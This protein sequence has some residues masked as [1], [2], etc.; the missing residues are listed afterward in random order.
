MTGGRFPNRFSEFEGSSRFRVKYTLP[1][2]WF[3]IERLNSL[4]SFS[5]DSAS[6]SDSLVPS[7]CPKRFMEAVGTKGVTQKILWGPSPAAR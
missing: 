2:H 4:L 1:R 3:A 6:R 5:R 7:Y